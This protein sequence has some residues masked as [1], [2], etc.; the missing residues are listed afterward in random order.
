MILQSSNWYSQSM[1]TRPSKQVSPPLSPP[2]QYLT[3]K[4][5][6]GSQNFH[7][8]CI[9][10]SLSTDQEVTAT[11]DLPL[12]FERNVTLEVTAMI[13]SGSTNSKE[14]TFVTEL[15]N[16][17]LSDA[18]GIVCNITYPQDLLMSKLKSLGKNCTTGDPI[19]CTLGTVPGTQKTTIPTS[20]A[21]E[22][23]KKKKKK[24]VRVSSTSDEGRMWLK[25]EMPNE[26]QYHN[27]AY[28][29]FFLLLLLV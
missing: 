7:M 9:G 12:S 28:C 6:L 15:T 22:L 20:F 24:Q 26:Q 21:S 16:K 11:S 10:K 2:I 14:L 19:S 13:A 23:R 8:E 4:I 5:E 29:F 1:P 18:D 3:T 27:N 17:G 25:S